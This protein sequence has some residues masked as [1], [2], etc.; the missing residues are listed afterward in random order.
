M[1]KV[2]LYYLLFIGI[3]SCTKT[4]IKYINNYQ[5]NVIV[6]ALDIFINGDTTVNNLWVIPPKAIVHFGSGGHIHGKGTMQGGIIDAALTQDIFDTTFSLSN[7]KTYNQDFSVCWYGSKT[8][9]K[10]N[11]NNLQK[12]INTCIDNNLKNCFIPTGNYTYSKPLTITN[13]YKGN[14]VG[15][16][17]R[18]YGEGQYWNDRST[19]TYTGLSGAALGIQYG[20]GTEIDHLKI[21][22]TFLPPVTTDSTY[23]NTLLT[24]FG[25]NASTYGL[26]IDYDGTKNAGGSTGIKVHDMW[27]TNFGTCYSVSPNS[28]T[29][30]GDILVFENIRCGEARIGFQS[31]QAQEK[32]N[33]IRGIYSWGKIHTLISIGQSGKFQAGNYTIDGGNIAGNCIRLFDIR[34]S[35]WFPSSISNLYAES[36]ATIGTIYAGDSKNQLPTEIKSCTFD[37]GY[38]NQVGKQNLFSGNSLYTKFSSCLFRYYGDYTSRMKMSGWATF[39]NCYFSCGVGGI[40]NDNN[41]F[42]F[43]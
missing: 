38:I 23:A 19:L 15:V 9:N 5:N 7:I 33:V 39:E 34:E 29:F 3:F 14:Y 30:N 4:E 35:G 17:I 2:T 8:S 24:S 43:K 27:V 25:T 36:I 37:F 1:K 22:G 13:I 16:S 32:G 42:I 18:F 6:S 41:G 26:V 21:T 28:V 10:D 12:A 40:D 20:K 31:N 11:S